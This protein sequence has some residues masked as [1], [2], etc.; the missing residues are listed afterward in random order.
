LLFVLYAEDRG[1][2]PIKD[3]RFDDYALREKRLD[4]GK[5]KDANDT[6]SSVAENLWGHFKNLS[7][8]IDKGDASVGL[9]PY[10]G[11][12]FSTDQT[13]LLNAIGLG[14]DVMA[15]AIDILSFEKPDG[16][17]R[18]IN[19]RDLSVQQLGSIYERL[20][21]FELTRDDDGVVDIRPN[22]FA[23]KNSGSYYTPDDLV[24]LILDETLEPLIT[25]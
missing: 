2:L 18:Y 23:R 9:P 13:P 3:A 11:G 5:R 19:Y 16:Q 24:L 22:I 14:D 17:R 10:N 12:L 6:F 20:L 25:D 4:V 8:M 21:E 7:K 15:E 1:L